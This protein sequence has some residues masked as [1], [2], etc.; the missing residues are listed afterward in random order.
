M[1]RQFKFIL[2]I[3]I[4]VTTV[5][6]LIYTAVDQ[7]KLYMVTVDQFVGTK[8]AFAGQHVR[9]AGRVQDDSMH[10]DAGKRRLT[11]TLHDISGD[12]S[13]KVAYSGLLP[14]MFAEGRDVIVEGPD[15]DTA[16]FEAASILTSCPSKYEPE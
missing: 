6:V 9:I 10:W 15:Q 2:G 11:F 14:D 1:N 8:D 5:A 13:I 12:G 16:T 7:T 4:I 3:G